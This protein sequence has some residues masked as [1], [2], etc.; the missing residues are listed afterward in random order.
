MQQLNFDPLVDGGQP[1]GHSLSKTKETLRKCLEY[2]PIDA[3]KLVSTDENSV[4]FGIGL[5]GLDVQDWLLLDQKNGNWAQSVWERGSFHSGARFATK[6]LSD[7]CCFFCASMGNWADPAMILRQSPSSHAHIYADACFYDQQQKKFITHTKQA[8]EAVEKR[9]N[10][11]CLPV[12]MD[13]NHD[14][15]SPTMRLFSNESIFCLENT[16]GENHCWFAHLGD[17][18][19]A[20]LVVL[21]R[22][23]IVKPDEHSL[24]PRL[25]AA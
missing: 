21:N 7:A 18:L 10:E 2:L 22:T 13:G 8:F 3:D 24:F 19:K 4:P 11:R 12:Y 15:I 9:F 20:M 23:S 1:S 6:S 5:D 17:A 14:L 16:N 25:D